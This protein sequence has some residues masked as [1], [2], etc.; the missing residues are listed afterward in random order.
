MSLAEGLEEYYHKHPFLKRGH[1]LSADARAFFRCHDAVHVVYGC[2]TS[3]TKEAVVKLSGI[4][5]A[6]GGLAV[7]SG[8]ALHESTDIYRKLTVLEILDTVLASLVVVPRTIWRC[9]RQE[10]RWPWSQFDDRLKTPLVDLRA[11][12]DIRVA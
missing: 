3:L 12:S 2:D 8:Y 4:F 10:S 7:L 5:G 6:T 9:A 11:Q 1:E